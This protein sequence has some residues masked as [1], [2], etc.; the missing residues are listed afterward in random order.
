MLEIG[1]GANIARGFSWAFWIAFFTALACALWHGKTWRRKLLYGFL[2]LLAFT[3]PVFPEIYRTLKE[4]QKYAKARALFNERCKIAVEKIHKNVESVDGILLLN[5]RPNDASI[6]REN[7]NWPDAGLPDEAGGDSYINSFLSW[8]H[9]QHP[10]RRGY[11]NNQ[12]L[13]R[14][15]HRSF[16]GY[17]FV[18]V[19]A[20]DGTFSRYRF[21]R[22]VENKM[23][24]ES[25]NDTQARYA[26]SFSNMTDSRDRSMWVAGTTVSII[27]TQ[28]NEV[29]AE[30][31]WY[32]FEPGQGSTAGARAPWGFAETCPAQG[33]WRGGATR[34]FVDQVLKPNQGE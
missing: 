25:V 12:P 10:P 21:Q 24:K 14:N 26:V 22:S 13:N 32:S 28:T 15:G 30:K 4:K 3:S 5:V 34:M 33:N 17:A 23:V 19:K 20:A 7:P 18:E 2:V 27:D 6:Q 11:L 29:I 31:T 8:E 9:Q 16:P 1:I